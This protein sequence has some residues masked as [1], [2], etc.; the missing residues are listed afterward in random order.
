M[1]RVLPFPSARRHR[2]RRAR[3]EALVAHLIDLL[4]ALDAAHADREPEPD[5][6]EGGEADT[7]PL[8]LNISLAPQRRIRRER[9]AG[10]E[11]AS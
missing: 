6:D 2:H 3:I 9:V 7:A 8:S 10:A 11:G 1:T 5:E 4:D